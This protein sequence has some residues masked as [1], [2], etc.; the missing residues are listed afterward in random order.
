[1][2][3]RSTL[4]FASNF[5]SLVAWNVNMVFF[6][7]SPTWFGMLN[8]DGI[9]YTLESMPGSACTDSCQNLWMHSHSCLEFS[10]LYFSGPSLYFDNYIFQSLFWVKILRWAYADWIPTWAY[11]TNMDISVH[12]PPDR[13]WSRCSFQFSQAPI[14]SGVFLVCESLRS[15]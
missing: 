4:A 2:L 11:I 13:T 1:M 10:F 9:Q 5:Y 8:E 7:G 3:N 6:W 12:H 14:L 15:L